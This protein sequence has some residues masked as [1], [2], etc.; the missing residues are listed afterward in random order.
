MLQIHCWKKYDINGSGSSPSLVGLTEVNFVSLLTW[1][2]LLFFFYLLT[3]LIF[4]LY[5]IFYMN[6]RIVLCFLC[7]P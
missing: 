6:E 2:A 5:M 3:K 1:S 7:Y 4:F